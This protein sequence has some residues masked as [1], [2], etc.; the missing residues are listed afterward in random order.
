MRGQ[1]PRVHRCE[2]AV[3][4]HELVGVRPVVRDVALVEGAHH[5]RLPPRA[6]LLV[7]SR[8]VRVDRTRE[9]GQHH[10]ADVAVHL[11][12]VDVEPGSPGRMRSAGSRQHLGVERRKALVQHRVWGAH[13]ELAVRLRRDPFRAGIRAEVVIEGAILLNDHHDVIDLEDPGRGARR[14]RTARG[15]DSCDQEANANYP[16]AQLP[17]SRRTPPAHG[18]KLS[19][20]EGSG[21]RA[22]PAGPIVCLGLRIGIAQRHR[23]GEPVAAAQGRGHFRETLHGGRHRCGRRMRRHE[24]QPS[25]LIGSVQALP[26]TLAS[27]GAHGRRL[28]VPYLDGTRAVPTTCEVLTNVDPSRI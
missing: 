14:H 12:L 3:L 22:L 13:R 8:A 24:L 16:G 2:H 28:V 5:V 4:Q 26:V 10:R 19:P 1:A 18:W 17:L 15:S 20:T 27:L 11:P 9:A 25:G 23:F 6:V 7:A 21:N